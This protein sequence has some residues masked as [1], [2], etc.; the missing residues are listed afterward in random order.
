MPSI[1]VG[2]D[3]RNRRSRSPKCAPKARAQA[4]AEKK[5]AEAD[6]KKA[7]GERKKE[8]EAA[9]RATATKKSPHFYRLPDVLERVSVSRSS[10]YTWIAA[11]QFPKWITVGKRTAV[12]NSAEVDAWIEARL[13]GEPMPPA[14]KR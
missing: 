14:K 5:R 3:D 8:A 4:L 9:E 2:H 10:V 6:K 1:G 12:W 11:G 7:E 13:R